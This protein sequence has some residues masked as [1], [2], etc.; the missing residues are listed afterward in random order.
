MKQYLRERNER[1]RN[2]V[3]TGLGLTIGL[4]LAAFLLV[5]F[6]GLTYL[7]PPPPE[8]TFV[9]DF[10]E[11]DEEVVQQRRGREPQAEEIDRTRPIELVQ[12]AESPEVADRQNLTPA[13]KQD[14]FG[15]V[16]TPEVPVKEEPKIDPRASFPGMAKKDTS[17]TAPH[18]AQSASDKYNAGHPDG[19]TRTGN[20]EGTPNAHVKGRNTVGNLPRPNYASQ[21]SG[22]V[23]VTIWVDNY[24]TV[25]KA[26]ASA[27][28]TTVTDKSLW[29]EARKAAMSTHFNMD[30]DAPAMQQGT[31]T[32]I[33]KLK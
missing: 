18:A 32:Y 7:Y 24:G 12:R 23:V 3:L 20:S 9:V 19:N 6:S 2:S 21:E 22:T 5:S 1:E 10:E 8:S 15:D 31:I 27:D 11:E 13:T 28:G 26:V 25:Q 29:A 30:A 33:F 17:L 16:E 14:D 4:H